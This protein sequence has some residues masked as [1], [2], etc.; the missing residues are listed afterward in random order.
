LVIDGADLQR[1]VT[2]L[3]TPIQKSTPQQYRG[4]DCHHQQHL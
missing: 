2:P 1:A 3:I 4:W